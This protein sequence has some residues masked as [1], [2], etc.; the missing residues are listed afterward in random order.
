MGLY[1]ILGICHH[2]KHEKIECMAIR[3]LDRSEKSLLWQE[4][5]REKEAAIVKAKD[6]FLSDPQSG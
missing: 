2:L 3:V 6:G 5:A 1:G 4:K